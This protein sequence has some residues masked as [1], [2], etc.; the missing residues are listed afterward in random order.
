MLIVQLQLRP[1]DANERVAAFL[2]EALERVFPAFA[3]QSDGRAQRINFEIATDD[4]GSVWP[5]LLV[6]L[7]GDAA[8]FAKLQQRWIVVAEG[9]CGWDDYRMLA[10]FDPTVQVD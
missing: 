2:R 7:R 5:A 1:D 3:E 4:I 6:D 9:D 10:H 8:S